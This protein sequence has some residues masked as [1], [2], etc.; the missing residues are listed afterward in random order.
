M[1]SA[2]PNPL[3]PTFERE[4]KTEL[5]ITFLWYFVTGALLGAVVWS[6]SFGHTLDFK[7]V[8]S[9]QMFASHQTVANLFFWGG[10]ILHCALRA[11]FGRKSLALK[12][13]LLLTASGF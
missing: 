9:A 12:N 8:V 3:E 7:R 10:G 5:S 1:H 2:P 11:Y 13:M 4:N 6:C